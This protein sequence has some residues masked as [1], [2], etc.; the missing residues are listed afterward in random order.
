[1]KFIH[2]DYKGKEQNVN[3][4]YLSVVRLEGTFLHSLLFYLE[5][6][7]S[8]MLMYFTKDNNWYIT[9]LIIRQLLN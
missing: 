8:G 5:I 1:M 7:F 2:N 4:S 6:F 9:L 3:S